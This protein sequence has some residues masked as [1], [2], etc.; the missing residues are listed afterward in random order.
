MRYLYESHIGSLFVSDDYLSFEETYCE[1]CG[2]CDQ[3]LGEFET[4]NDFW[5][6]IED[7]CSI[8]GGGGYNLQYV[9]PMMVKMF[10]LPDKVEYDNYLDK[11][12]GYC[13]AK[14]SDIIS[15]IEEL[16]GRKVIKND[17]YM[18]EL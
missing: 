8:D 18:H 5:N 4:I 2:D 11:L 3:L 13:K 17:D 7:K 14:E 12:T 9:Y 16:I 10:D 1:T 6:L 15:R